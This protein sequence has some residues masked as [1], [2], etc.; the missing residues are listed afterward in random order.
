M[1]C[2][3]IVYLTYRT[4]NRTVERSPASPRVMG[5]AASRTNPAHDRRYRK[6]AG[7]KAPEDSEENEPRALLAFRC[8][9][10]ASRAKGDGRSGLDQCGQ[11]QRIPVTEA[12]AAVRF[13][14]SDVGRF[15][16]AMDAV[17]LL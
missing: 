1:G 4:A 6:D 16:R 11:P 3:G 8:Q 9:H 12:N 15:R 10:E 17:V 14:A 7:E 5:H 13:A 2:G